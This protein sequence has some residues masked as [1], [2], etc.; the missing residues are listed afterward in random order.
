MNYTASEL[1]DI[2]RPVYAA[3]CKAQDD[4]DASD[5]AN[6]EDDDLE[7]EMN[8]ALQRH[9]KVY[10]DLLEARPRTP[11]EMAAMIIYVNEV[12]KQQGDKGHHDDG[13]AILMANLKEI[14][15]LAE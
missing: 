7:A 10:G 11:E 14:V 5:E 3:L 15:S 6:P 9:Q 13:P 8:K 1:I 12:A 2:D 4:Y